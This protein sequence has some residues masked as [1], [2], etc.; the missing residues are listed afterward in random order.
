MYWMY[1]RS[2]RVFGGLHVNSVSDSVCIYIRL[3]II[4]SGLHVH[5][6]MSPF[7]VQFCNPQKRKISGK[8]NDTTADC[9]VWSVQDLTEMVFMDMGQIPCRCLYLWSDHTRWHRRFLCV[10][11]FCVLCQEFEAGCTARLTFRMLHGTF[12]TH[13]HK[14]V[15]NLTRSLSTKF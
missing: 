10:K 13:G 9:Q 7:S 15:T 14:K 11:T 6:A 1:I 12:L 8:R 5:F 4:F 3:V 2:L